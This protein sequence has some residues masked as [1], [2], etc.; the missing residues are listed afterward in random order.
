[1]TG[2]RRLLVPAVVLATAVAVTQLA[3]GNGGAAA[4]HAA[5]PPTQAQPQQVV[6]RPGDTM[7]VEGA[8]LMCQVARR[9]GRPTVQ[10]RRTGGARGTYGTFLDA[11]TAIVARFHSSTTAQT[12]FRA[13]HHGDWTACTAG[14]RARAAGEHCR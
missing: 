3:T 14:P 9:A 5:P 10:C 11:R 8:P 1:M 4:P 6:L 2:P 13:R 12:V 7:R